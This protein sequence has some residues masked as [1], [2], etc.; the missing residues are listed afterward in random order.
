MT[1]NSP[2]S[3]LAHIVRLALQEDIGDGDITSLLIAK[4]L[5]VKAHIVCREEAILCG[6]AWVEEAY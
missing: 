1:H 2:P 4:G 3:D 6:I 5:Q